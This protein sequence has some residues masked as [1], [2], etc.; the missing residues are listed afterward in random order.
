MWATWSLCSAS[1]EGSLTDLWVVLGSERL[2]VGFGYPTTAAETRHLVLWYSDQGGRASE[3]T[4]A[5][6]S[7][8]PVFVELLLTL[9]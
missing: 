5:I 7:P 6:K 4:L 3:Y 1:V 8:C 2:T 9:L